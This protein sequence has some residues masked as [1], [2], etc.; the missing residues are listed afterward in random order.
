MTQDEAL[1]PASRHPWTP[2]GS[3]S[4]SANT[5]SLR[6]YAAT[7]QARHW[8]AAKCHSSAPGLHPGWLPDAQFT[9]S[10]DAADFFLAEKQLPEH[11]WQV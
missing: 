1:E 6:L 8:V 11:D 3:V 2:D 4:G 10:S 7:S 9:K 5:G